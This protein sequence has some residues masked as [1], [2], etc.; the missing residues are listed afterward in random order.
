MPLH[1]GDYLGDTGH[2]TNAQHGSY[3]LLI[4]HYW[5]NGGLPNDDGQIQAIARAPPSE[6]PK[7]REAIASFFHHEWRHKRIDREIRRHRIISAKRALAGKRGG[8]VSGLARVKSDTVPKR[9]KRVATY[10][11]QLKK[12]LASG[13]ADGPQK[14]EGAADDAGGLKASE[15]LAAI[16]AARQQAPDKAG[17]AGSGK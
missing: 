12:D 5:L 15:E 3:L 9:S 6:W 4:M 7:I 10:N 17:P 2:L 11:L 16:V 1:I 14:Q 13:R 8:L